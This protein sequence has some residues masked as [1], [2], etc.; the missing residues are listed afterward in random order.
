M[1]QSPENVI[2][3]GRFTMRSFFFGA[4]VAASTVLFGI[5]DRKR[6]KLA[7]SFGMKAIIPIIAA[8][9]SGGGGIM[10]C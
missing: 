6:H 2:E 8:K 3:R 7:I 1:Q 4:I 9:V 10:C 5:W